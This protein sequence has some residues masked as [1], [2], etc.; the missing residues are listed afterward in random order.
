MLLP[1]YIILYP[2]LGALENTLKSP[3]DRLAVK[4]VVEE[5]D[6]INLKL[7]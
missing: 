1:L 7:N 2:V 4:S 3:A 6:S 5:E